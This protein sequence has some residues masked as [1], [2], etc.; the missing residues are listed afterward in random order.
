MRVGIEWPIW[1]CFFVALW[2]IFGWY[3]AGPF[4]LVSIGFLALVFVAWVALYL[5]LVCR[6]GKW[7]LSEMIKAGY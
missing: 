1:A 6:T 3:V 2:A 4:L 5:I 7:S